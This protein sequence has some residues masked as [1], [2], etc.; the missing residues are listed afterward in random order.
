MDEKRT[1]SILGWI[2]GSL[3]VLLRHKS[4]RGVILAV[5]AAQHG[6]RDRVTTSATIR[7][8]RMVA[9]EFGIWR[10]G[11]N[12]GASGSVTVGNGKFR[13]ERGGGRF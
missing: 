4:L 9:T 2:M 11:R 13:E 8:R 10:S 7:C 1:L 12:G 6:H 5:G 3:L